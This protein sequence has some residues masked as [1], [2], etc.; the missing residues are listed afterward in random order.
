MNDSLKKII[1]KNQNEKKAMFS[2]IKKLKNELEKT[3]SN[4]SKENN[5]IINTEKK[6]NNEDQKKNNANDNINIVFTSSDGK[7]R[8]EM[9]CLK[10]DLFAKIEDRFYKKYINFRETNNM[11]NANGKPILRFK[12]ISENNIKDG[13]IIQLF[14]L[15]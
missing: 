4:I 14:I 9:K 3:K 8:Y 1:E 12:N 15:G 10:S 13:D 2:T 11:F 6:V 5:Q 7:I